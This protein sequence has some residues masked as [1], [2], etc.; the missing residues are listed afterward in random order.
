MGV[1]QPSR[2]ERKKPVLV[3]EDSEN[4]ALLIQRQLR[5]HGV[6]NPIT[7]LGNGDEALLYFSGLGKYSN[8]DRYPLPFVLLLDV[9]LP[10]KNDGLAVLRSVRATPGF[11]Q[12]LIVM[13]SELEDPSVI[14]EAYHLGANSYLMKP[15]NGE[16][17]RN[18]LNGFS[19]YWAVESKAPV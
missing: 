17:I 19:R 1:D 15:P 11:E 7:V 18:L 13:I 14:R 8:R 16:E 12:L 10:G 9:K 2:L 4:D 5:L 3:V 6:I